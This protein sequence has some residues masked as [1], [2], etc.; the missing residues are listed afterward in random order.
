M[1]RPSWIPLARTAFGLLAAAA[2]SDL[3]VRY[4]RDPTRTTANFFRYFTVQSNLFAAAV[5]LTGA[6]RPADRRASPMTASVRGAAVLYLTTTGVI[7]E[8]LLAGGVRARG[9]GVPWADAVV[10]RVMPLVLAADWLLD[11]PRTRLAA[12]QALGWVAYPLA[13]VAYSLRRGASAG[14]YP[15]PFLD[16][17]E[18][19]GYPRVVMNCAGIA[20]FVLLAAWSVVAVGNVPRGVREPDAS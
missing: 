1:E 15:Y 3:F 19:G 6:A 10:H 5:L 18:A 17:R 2:V 7:Y 9:G 20:G 11:P 12:G 16:P 14:W 13:Y 4:R 8:V